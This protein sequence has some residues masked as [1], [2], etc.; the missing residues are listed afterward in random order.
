MMAGIDIQKPLTSQDI[1]DAN[2][3]AL[4]FASINDSKRDQALIYLSALRDRQMMEDAGNVK[5][6]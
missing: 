1:E 3:I 6:A 4:L 2:K 5:Q